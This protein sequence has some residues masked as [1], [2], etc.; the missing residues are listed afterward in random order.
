MLSVLL[1]KCAVGAADKVS[2][3]FFFNKNISF[4]RGL[5]ANFGLLLHVFCYSVETVCKAC[6]LSR[7][8]IQRFLRHKAKL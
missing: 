1:E 7:G 5:C 3:L 2:F 4:F 8:V 6:M